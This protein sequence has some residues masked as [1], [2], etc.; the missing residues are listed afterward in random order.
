M[1]V[2]TSVLFLILAV[3]PTLSQSIFPGRF[4][5]ARS[6]GLGNTVVSTA[7]SPFAALR[8][9]AALGAIQDM[10]LTFSSNAFSDL[11][12]IGATQF[13]PGFGSLAI[14][15]TRTDFDLYAAQSSQ[16]MQTRFDRMTIA[17]GRNVS[18][19]FL[20]G[21][22]LHWNH[23]YRNHFYTNSDYL[24]FSLGLLVFPAT[25]FEWQRLFPQSGNL[26]NNVI[27]PQ[28]FSMGIVVQD[29][30][31]GKKGFD[32]YVDIGAY[33]RLFKDGP[34]LL[35]AL[36]LSEEKQILGLGFNLPVTRNINMIT[37]IEDFRIKNTAFGMSFL[38]SRYSF[39][40]AYSL[41]KKELYLDYTMR[42]GKSPLQRA[43]QYREKG[44][45]F[46]KQGKH[47]R[48]LKELN[49]Y[50]AYVPDDS[51]TYVLQKWLISK[52][53]A[54]ESQ[55]RQLFDIAAKSEEKNWYIRAALIYNFI[56]QMDEG[57]IEASQRLLQIDPL[58]TISL[59]RLYDK[60]LE[61]FR[62]GNYRVAEKAFTT[63]LKI[64]PEHE[65][66]VYY[67]QKI[68]DDYSEK[69]NELYFRGLGFFNQKRYELAI[70]AFDEAIEYVRDNHKTQNS[71]ALAKEKLLERNRERERLTKLAQ[72]YER[73]K[74]FINAFHT[75]T[76]I[77]AANP[78]DDETNYAIRRIT[79]Q[80][81]RSLDRL[82]ERGRQAFAAGKIKSARTYFQSLLNYD[83]T[84][85]IANQFLRRIEREDKRLIEAIYGR[86]IADFDRG[87]WDKA[88]ASF[89]TV[90]SLENDYKAA[91]EKRREALAK[92]SFEELLNI[93]EV[94]YR[95]GQFMKALDY[96]EQILARVPGN[97]YI[98]QQMADCREKMNAFVDLH[99]NKAIHLYAAQ[100]YLGTIRECEA[101]LNANPTHSG[102]LEYLKKARE[103][104]LAV[105]ALQ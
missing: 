69:A 59:Y 101:V 87:F 22:S 24:T 102:S 88:I 41:Q 85:Q 5:G 30:P 96:Y 91:K 25:N 12:F 48:A 50:L 40:I 79:P 34:T 95:E 94:H 37:G 62:A 10:R 3:T 7:Q 104:R 43:K 73:K 36:R 74:Q 20:A 72:S 9:P 97:Q 45:Y 89:D 46:A 80:L 38:F 1:I 98:I 26:F 47:R 54:R 28:K 71:R 84:N 31:F 51:V 68:Y 99:F 56:L 27:L 93:A 18:N 17:F 53:Q 58:V 63:I 78:D 42:I 77:L 39:D 44:V 16:D 49:K 13:Y 67:L 90:L 6:V 92:S 4:L 2:L 64:Q 61:E 76:Q 14:S 29:I 70:A 33:Y 81:N 65:K 83:H 75:Y 55:I 21:A 66:S 100:D 57:N 105:E 8:N 82:V 32:P 35:G 103:R 11:G 15:Y 52:V 23:F 60:G 19:L 86:A